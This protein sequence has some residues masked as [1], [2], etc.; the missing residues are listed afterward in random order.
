VAKTVEARFRLGGDRSRLREQHDFWISVGWTAWALRRHGQTLNLLEMPNA[1]SL[2]SLHPQ[3]TLW[4]TA[5]LTHLPWAADTFSAAAEKIRTLGKPFPRPWAAAAVL[6]VEAAHGIRLTDDL[7]VWR[8]ALRA[9]ALWTRALLEAASPGTRLHDALTTTWDR[10]DLMR[11]DLELRWVSRG[12][13]RAAREAAQA[14]SE[15]R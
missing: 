8:H 6:I 3:V 14:L 4:G 2:Q 11:L 15:V 7:T 9:G 5:W 10:L 1:K 13:R 12:W